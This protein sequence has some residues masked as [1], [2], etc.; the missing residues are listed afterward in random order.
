E[1]VPSNG[2]IGSEHDAP[3]LRVRDM[4]PYRTVPPPPRGHFVR[5]RVSYLPCAGIWP[6]VL[7]IALGVPTAW[8]ARHE[9]YAPSVVSCVISPVA[10]SPHLGMIH[11]A[12]S[13]G[14]PVQAPCEELPADLEQ[15]LGP[16]TPL[17]R[18]R[19]QAI[20]PVPPPTMPQQ[21]G[22]CVPDEPPRI[23]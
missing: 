14:A 20:E 3:A 19:I 8:W 13:F 7:A 9:S 11:G 5:A 2:G 12:G 18:P 22:A 23:P 16:R 1:H 21:D 10:E 17:S 15:V 4:T 6:L